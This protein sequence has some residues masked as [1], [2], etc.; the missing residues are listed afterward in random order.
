[1]KSRKLFCPVRICG[2]SC[3]VEGIEHSHPLLPGRGPDVA[4]VIATDVTNPYDE[5]VGEHIFEACPSSHLRVNIRFHVDKGVESGGEYANARVM[6]GVSISQSL[7][8]FS[9]QNNM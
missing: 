4:P 2:V 9:E 6:K 8:L 1:M 5:V 7:C 3:F